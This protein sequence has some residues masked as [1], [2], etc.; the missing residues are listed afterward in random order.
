MIKK[1]EI[2]QKYE[3]DELSVKIFGKTTFLGR[4]LE[5]WCFFGTYYRKKEIISQGIKYKITVY[6]IFSF[7]FD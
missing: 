1:I 2:D 6:I 4:M 7:S 3:N 5:K